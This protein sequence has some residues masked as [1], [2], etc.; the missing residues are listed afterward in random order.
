MGYRKYAKD[1]EI[2]YVTQPGKK[3]PKAVRIY[4]GPY[5]RFQADPARIRK[6]RWL[7]L[8]GLVLTA[9]CLLV[10]MMIDCAFTR[11]W[12]VQGPA[13]AAWI[14]WCLASGACWRLWTARDKV[15]REHCDLLYD[16][17]GSASLFLMGLCL[18]SCVGCVLAQMN[19][20]PAPE[21]CTVCLC[22]LASAAIGIVLFSRRKE[23]EMVPEENPEKPQAGKHRTPSPEEG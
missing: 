21:D 15:V 5:F 9:V 23:L 1:Y 8:I 19:M 7:Y 4:V 22:S 12:Y 3:H 11:T 6:L 17:M 14:P 16:R 13:A 10:P 18:C 2:E 20:T